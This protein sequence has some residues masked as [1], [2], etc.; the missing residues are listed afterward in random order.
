M[1]CTMPDFG[2]EGASSILVEFMSTFVQVSTLVFFFSTIFLYHV[3]SPDP[4]YMQ[5]TAQ[6]EGTSRVCG[7]SSALY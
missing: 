4:T 5:Q 2:L 7:S 6:Q 3:R 1:P